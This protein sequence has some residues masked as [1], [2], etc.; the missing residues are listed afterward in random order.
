MSTRVASIVADIGINTGKFDKGVSSVLKSLG[1]MKGDFAKFGLAVGAAGVVI[2]AVATQMKKAVDVTVTYADK[3]RTLSSVT[4]QSAETTSR[5]IQVLDDY[6]LSAQQAG[7]AAK[8]LSKEG[9]SLN[10]ETLAKLS[11]EY[12]TLNTGQE[13][14][15][16]LMKNFGKAGQDFTL[17][18]EQGSE[19][20][21]ERAGL[22]KEGLI[23]SQKELKAAQDLK[24]AQDDLN[25]AQQEMSVQLGNRLIPLQ[26]KAI[27][28]F[29]EGASAALGWGD[30][31]RTIAELMTQ[32]G[33]PALAGYGV[34]LKNIWG[35]IEITAD[36][37]QDYA[38]EAAIAAQKT[39]ELSKEQQSIID[40][41]DD[42]SDALSSVGDGGKEMAYGILQ[43]KLAADGVLNDEDIQTLLRYKESLGL[44]TQQEYEAA[45]Q[46]LR[47]RAAL[48]GIP[49]SV[50][51]TVTINE[52]HNMLTTG[53]TGTGQTNTRGAN[54][55]AVGNAVGGP[56]GSGWTMV[57]EVGP[58]LIS[59]SG[60]VINAHNT[61]RMLNRGMVPG[62]RFPTGGNIAVGDFG[63]NTTGYV[64]PW[65]SS[66]NLIS[67]MVQGNPNPLSG[68]YGGADPVSGGGSGGGG[69][70]GAVVRVA[71]AS[72]QASQQSAQASRAM[73]SV[74]QQSAQ[75]QAASNQA[76]IGEIR[77]LRQ[78]F[79]R[80]VRDAVLQAIAQ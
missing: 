3:V 69:G 45:Q 2:G 61:R 62:R 1:L 7:M 11:D 50:Q 48:L 41:S 33:N 79:P 72:V 46:A 35:D 74:S 19:A 8:F 31:I 56:V 44:L 66:R 59:P 32:Q 52:I 13:R 60:M 9:L 26:T 70:S 42:L 12:K 49:A 47:I 57:G 30:Q 14:A 75:M 28:V 25:D 78:E 15:E 58:E 76:L 36:A 22:V 53:R 64:A 65:V 38:S 27:N 55:L 5:M 43:A 63:N 20:I 21:K 24:Y 71:S 17:V 80:A 51:S 68:L 34:L 39:R 73:V 67:D 54:T 10:I 18:M 4:N 16:F 23:L 40:R 29:T 77:A 37:T 6:G